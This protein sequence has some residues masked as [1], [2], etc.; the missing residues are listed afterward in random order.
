MGGIEH[1]IEEDIVSSERVWYENQKTFLLILLI[2]VAALSLPYFRII[3][4]ALPNT[5]PVVVA[6]GAGVFV[7][8]MMY[9]PMHYINSK[10]AL[11]SSVLFGIL[12]AEFCVFGA[13]CHFPAPIVIALFF[14]IFY[15][16]YEEREH[17]WPA[18]NMCNTE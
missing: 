4:D 18:N 7:T 6:L 14:F 3:N 10:Y 16:A 9:L 13:P 15:H 17:L 1:A 11:S 12:V 5:H 8:A 2:F